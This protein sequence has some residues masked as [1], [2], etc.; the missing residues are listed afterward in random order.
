[1][2]GRPTRDELYRRLDDAFEELRDRLGGLPAP[3]EAEGIWTSIWYEE[4]H[5]STALE[6]NTLALKQVER[7]LADGVAVGNRELREY[8][9]VRG[10][11]DAASWVYGQA[12]EPGAW[13]ATELFSLTELRQIHASAIGPAWSVAPHPQASPR[14][15]PGSFREHDIAPFPGGM[16]PPP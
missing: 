8:M 2:A 6:G 13:R 15:S 5:N 10:Y 14:E 11:A 1:M 9:E 7:L 16:T 4:A 3:L 12:L